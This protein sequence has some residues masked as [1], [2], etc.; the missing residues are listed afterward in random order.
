MPSVEKATPP[1]W[2][3]CG[4]HGM[5]EPGSWGYIAVPTPGRLSNSGIPQRIQ[6]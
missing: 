3:S 2:R 6:E 1:G 4:N 5:A